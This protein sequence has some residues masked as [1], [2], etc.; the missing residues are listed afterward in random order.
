M[1]RS[2]TNLKA[3]VKKR[4]DVRV[5][6]ELWHTANCLLSAGQKE[7]TGSAHQFRGSLLFRAFALEAFL[8]WLGHHL[9]PHWKYLERLKPREKLDLLTDLTHVTPDY[10]SRPWQIVK[11]LF[12][13]RNEIAHGKPESLTSET[14]EDVDDDLDTKLGEHIQADWE[15]FG[16]EQ[17]AVKAKEDVEKIASLLY[18]A[19]G[20]AKKQSGPIGPFTF[21]F[22][23]HGATIKQP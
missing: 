9:M 7:P 11:E 21:G 10:G 2:A 5:H 12:D 14:L 6:A 1:S 20:V 17:N 8:N 18:N 22:H 4:R 19:S 15:K 3:V 13:F 23:T 16:T